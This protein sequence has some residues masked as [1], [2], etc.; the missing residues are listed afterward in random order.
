MKS[1]NQHVSARAAAFIAAA[2]VLFGMSVAQGSA[3][4]SSSYIYVCRTDA[5]EIGIGF[6]KP[7]EDDMSPTP[8]VPTQSVSGLTH[9]ALSPGN[10]WAAL[11]LASDVAQLP[12]FVAQVEA[13]TD[14]QIPA[15][16]RADLLA[17]AEAI[18]AQ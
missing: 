2:A 10:E 6:I 8:A 18:E 16:C 14:E 12:D 15:G 11:T 13:L 1:I 3:Q 9:A 7:L 17:I 5:G 4:M